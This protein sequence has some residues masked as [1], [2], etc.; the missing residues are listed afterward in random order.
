MAV[1]A[2]K[3]A[4]QERKKL[5][6]EEEK[7]KQAEREAY[8]AS[9]PAWKRPLA[10]K[11]LEEERTVS[12]IPTEH[13]HKESTVASKAVDKWKSATTR[14]V[15][16]TPQPHPEPVRSF[17]PNKKVVTGTSHVKP[18]I[19]A[20][21]IAL[22]ERKSVAEAKKKLER[23]NTQPLPDVKDDRFVS[24]VR[25]ALG[26]N[27]NLLKV[28]EKFEQD[29]G[30]E[31]ETSMRPKI[32]KTQSLYSDDRDESPPVSP[33]QKEVPPI[34][35][36]FSPP[37]SQAASAGPVLPENDIP[38]VDKSEA[39]NETTPK[40]VKQHA[41]Q[42]DIP[43]END[44]KF[45]AMPLW[46]QELI[47][48]KRQQ[49]QQGYST[50]S[51]VNKK[52]QPSQAQTKTVTSTLHP[53][54][55]EVV[56]AS[57]DGRMESPTLVRKTD[58]GI[59]QRAPV[60]KSTSK[61]A[62]ITEN[63]PEFQKLPSWKQAVIRRRREDMEKRTA[64]VEKPQEKEV[65]KD[66]AGPIS[67]P[68]SKEMNR[69][70][71]QS[72]QQERNEITPAKTPPKV[73]VNEDAPPSAGGVSKVQ[74][75]LGQFSGGQVVRR[76]IPPAAPEKKESEVA[77]TL[78]DEDESDEEDEPRVMKTTR[79]GSILKDARSPVKRTLQVSWSETEL[80]KEHYY[81]K[82][83]YSDYDEIEQPE[84]ILDS[85]PEE[86]ASASSLESI[87]TP[88]HPWLASTNTPPSSRTI[89]S[90]SGS[91]GLDS[92]GSFMSM[93]MLN[94]S[95]SKMQSTPAKPNNIPNG[96]LKDEDDM[97]DYANMDTDIAALMF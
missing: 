47:R 52:V 69:Q 80:T 20:W 38:V 22:Q 64:P 59:T 27:K 5:K 49:Q 62:D 88:L 26:Q 15:D 21:K 46:K 9:L 19:P 60:I 95:P 36:E 31:T 81:Q 4:I 77:F 63:D 51:L 35:K 34:Q 75:L 65:K 70:Q 97:P 45:L 40:V 87:S 61:W 13:E 53:P 72:Q 11:K 68:W 42:Q 7:K 10:L 89:P 94:T 71:T 56:N 43:D 6:E 41:P 57:K 74:A 1:P 3:V 8:L 44:P 17:E 50:S 48:R 93:Y 55:P 67:T 58:E 90:Y 32:T 12:T 66:T 79:S 28:K 2:W 18:T 91:S 86:S 37:L 25:K 16:P 54:Q 39:N 73:V 14:K 82:Y 92:A 33:I 78:I 29:T 83:D 30:K 23:A 96:P 85:H 84:P 24:P 76:K